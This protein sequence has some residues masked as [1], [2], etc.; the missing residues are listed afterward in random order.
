MGGVI[1]GAADASLAKVHS[2]HFKLLTTQPPYNREAM[3]RI[4]A[5]IFLLLFAFSTHCYAMNIVEEQS[6]IP[7]VAGEIITTR[8]IGDETLMEIA[9]REGFG[10]EVVANSNRQLDPWN[11]GS[12][13]EVIL[14]GEAILPYGTKPGL[15]INLAELRLFHII[16]TNEGSYQINIYPLGIGREGRETPEGQYRVIV[17][18]EHPSWRVPEGLLT[19][20]PTL[21]KVM[22]AGPQNPLGDYWL[23]LSAPG[24][25]VHGTNRPLGVGRRVSYGCLRMYPQ[26][27]ASLYARVE[28]GTPVQISYQPIKAAWSG[29]YLLLEVHID[30]LERFKNPFQHALT[31]ISKTG[32]PG[33]IDYA[34]VQEVISAR[35]SLPEVVGNWFPE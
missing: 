22:P 18:K 34:Q 32:W 10:Y 30:Y 2:Y 26:D 20:N 7:V 5:H 15:M 9:R 3:K 14:P 28:V 6:K 16:D 27:I 11:P 8:T 31:M 23:G 17:K 19:R 25:G 21:P 24:Y 12:G 4:P 1:S 29:N 13:A 35:R 33:E